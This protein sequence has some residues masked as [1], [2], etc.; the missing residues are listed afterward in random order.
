MGLHATAKGIDKD[1]NGGYIG[2]MIFRIQLAKAI[3]TEFGDYYERYIRNTDFSDE[4]LEKLNDII[5]TNK[6]YNMD[7]I[8]EF[9]FHSDCD[10]SLSYQVCKK[11]YNTLK[12]VKLDLMGH[13]YIE[14]KE[15]N[16]LERWLY[17]FKF[18]ADNRSKIMFY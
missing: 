11:L 18:S 12:D 17:M 14:M 1:Y 4:D 15:Y 7:A 2:F 13:N 10:G 8:A 16:L 5:A 3:D 9:L 6:D